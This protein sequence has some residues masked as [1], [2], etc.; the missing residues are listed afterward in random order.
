MNDL[1]KL[2]EDNKSVERAK[3]NRETM[4]VINNIINDANAIRYI[5]EVSFKEFFLDYFFTRYTKGD[6]DKSTL[7]FKWLELAGGVYK[8]VGVV[9]LDGK[10]LYL[11]PSLYIEPKI[12]PTMLSKVNFSDVMSTY[13]LKQNHFRGS[14]DSY[15]SG[16]L[17]KINKSLNTD[18]EKARL[19]WESIFKKYGL[20]KNTAVAKTANS[21][22]NNLINYD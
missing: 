18:M 11:V 16:Y 8:K 20:I 15:L 13:Q 19:E 4:P 2:A 22:I 3:V 9:G 7:F 12:D 6:N 1:K 14:G 21:P 10:V 17:D 5:P